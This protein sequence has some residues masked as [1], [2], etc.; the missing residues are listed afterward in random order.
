MFHPKKQVVPIAEILKKV[1]VMA[2]IFIKGGRY[3]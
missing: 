1:V 2:E 3:G